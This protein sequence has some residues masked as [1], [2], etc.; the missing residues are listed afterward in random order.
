MENGGA[1]NAEECADIRGFLF[2]MMEKRIK[3]VDR[4]DDAT[5]VQAMDDGIKL[6]ASSSGAI[7]DE[8]R[9]EESD[10]GE[11]KKKKAKKTKKKKVD[12]DS[13]SPED[14]EKRQRKFES[15]SVDVGFV[16]QFK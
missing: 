14:E 12:S 5:V 16:T 15:I 9:V 6:L 3:W 4:S 7:G 2:E 13:D 8:T 11:P 10:E 1:F